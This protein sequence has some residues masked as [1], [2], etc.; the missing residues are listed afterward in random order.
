[1]IN[2]FKGKYAWLSNFYPCDNITLHGIKYPSVENAYQAAKTLNSE[3]REQFETCSSAQ[4]KHLGKKITLRED[5]DEECRL[6]TMMFLNFQKYYFNEDLKQKLLDTGEEEL[7]EGNYWNDTFWG[8]CK[9]KGKNHLGLILMEI[10]EQLQ[11]EK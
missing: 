11:N 1:M 3:E 10:R 8:V 6:V 5:W 4:A 2:S 7:V 9:G